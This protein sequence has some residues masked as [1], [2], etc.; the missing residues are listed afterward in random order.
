MT[1]DRPILEYRSPGAMTTPGGNCTFTF[2][3]P[4][5]VGDL[6]IQGVVVV[7]FT[8]GAIGLAV[9]GAHELWRQWSWTTLFLFAL[10]ITACVLVATSNWRH[11]RNGK[12]FGGL[13]VKLSISDDHLLMSNPARWGLKTVAVP[14]ERIRRC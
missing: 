4:A 2:A 5:I 11:L 3:P 12:R 14:L 10:F 7:L 1:Q 9:I 13:P 6:I 8:G